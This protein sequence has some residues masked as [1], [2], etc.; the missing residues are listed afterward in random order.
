MYNSPFFFEQVLTI[1]YYLSVFCHCFF[2]IT[3]CLFLPFS[4]LPIPVF[5][6]SDY[7]LLILKLSLSHSQPI[8]KESFVRHVSCQSLPLADVSSSQTQPSFYSRGSHTQHIYCTHL[9]TATSF[10][11]V[12]AIF[13]R[14]GLFHMN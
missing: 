8:Y 9:F 11:T 13:H 14:F 5:P 6:L 12:T 10:F 1:K 2:L 7:P 3:L 4:S